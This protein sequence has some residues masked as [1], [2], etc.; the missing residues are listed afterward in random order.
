LVVIP[1]LIT[2]YRRAMKSVRQVRA[3]STKSTFH[4]VRVPL[5]S[6]DTVSAALFRVMG[7]TICQNLIK[8]GR[9][10]LEKVAILF[11]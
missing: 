1:R 3:V 7:Y 2:E 11:R 6:V 8:V 4:V 9:V 10:I 5:F